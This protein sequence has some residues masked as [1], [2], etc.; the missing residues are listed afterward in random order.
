MATVRRALSGAIFAVLFS[1]GLFFN[2]TQPLIPWIVCIVTA[3]GIWEFFKFAERKD[4]K[5]QGVLA[6]FIGVLTVVEAYHFGLR[7]L[8]VL[9][10][11]ALLSSFLLQLLRYG[12]DHFLAHVSITF[13]GCF[14]VS[15]PM[16]MGMAVFHGPGH[17]T[18][19]RFLIFFLI[20]TVWSSD[21]GAYFIG[22]AWGRRK[23]AP[24]ISPGK[25]VEG[26]LGG[27]GAILLT[28]SAVKLLWPEVSRM[29][30]W[31]EVIALALVFCVVG[32]AGDL[33]ESALKRDAGVKNSSGFDF[34]GHGGMLD[35][36]DSLLF[37]LP[38]FYLYC[39]YLYPR[40]HPE[41]CP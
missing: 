3:I 34:T 14:Y 17:I 27:F 18:G 12:P 31:P 2:R 24:R 37:C 22:R 28:A 36:I 19:S 23:L 21:I 41:L 5:A 15:L 38:V 16:A 8:P 20:L 35:I 9:L 1:L 29:L 13:L 25:T 26:M 33:T 32:L 30:L 40:L 7:H 4:F 6:C 10:T 11:A 39:C